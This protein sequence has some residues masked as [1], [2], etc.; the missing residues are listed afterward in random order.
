M[1]EQFMPQEYQGEILTPEDAQ[2]AITDMN[3]AKAIAEKLWQ[4]Y[5][6][7]LWAVNADTHNNIANV[8][9]MGVSGQWGFVLH[10]D[11]IDPGMQIVMRAG[12][13]I[14][15]RYNLSRTGRKDDEYAG[16][17]RDFAGRIQHAN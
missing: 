12:G 2:R 14:L 8:Q 16:L 17:V 11:K 9:L 7:H 4:Q 1:T 10:L 13:E 5:P 3:T 15:E 6:G